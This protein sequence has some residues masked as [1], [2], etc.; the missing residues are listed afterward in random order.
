[1]GPLSFFCACCVP[2]ASAGGCCR[3]LAHRRR[4]PCSSLPATFPRSKPDKNPPFSFPLGA[5][6]WWRFGGAPFLP[7]TMSRLRN[8]AR[9]TGAV[10][11]IVTDH[12]PELCSEVSENL[13]KIT[14]ESRNKAALKRVRLKTMRRFGQLFCHRTGLAAH[15]G[16][17]AVVAWAR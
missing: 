7:E 12:P 14:E 1:M 17:I 8:L 15:R 13:E 5:L 2:A 4:R 16:D 11:M 9:T 6:D 3:R 10:R